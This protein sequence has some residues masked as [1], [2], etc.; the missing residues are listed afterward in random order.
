MKKLLISLPLL[1]FSMY[2]IKGQSKNEMESLF[3]R[4]ANQGDNFNISI[5]HDLISD[6]DF[7]FDFREYTEEMSGHIDRIRF[8]KFENY[9]RGLKS[10]KEFI[11]QM[12]AW[13]Y[14][15]API[16]SDWEEDQGQAIL[17][18][19]PHGK[20]SAHAAVLLNNPKDRNAILLIFSGD[21]IFKTY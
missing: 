18:R 20:N 12:L 17:L 7:D 9:E 3:N 19:K 21:L 13:G 14:R 8:V 1:L 15:Q 2:A 16:P 5:S 11:E 10:E 6:L 4:I